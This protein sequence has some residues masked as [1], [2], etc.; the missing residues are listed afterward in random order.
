MGIECRGESRRPDDV[1]TDRKGA[2]Y[3]Q[4]SQS[5][6]PQIGPPAR[7]V[8]GKGSR[9]RRQTPETGLAPH[10]ADNRPRNGRDRYSHGGQVLDWAA[11]VAVTTSTIAQM[12]RPGRGHWLRVP[13]IGNGAPSRLSKRLE[14]PDE[15]RQTGPGGAEPTSK[16]TSLVKSACNRRHCLV[17]TWRQ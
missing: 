11:V 4:S 12:P 9:R 1:K 7:V 13:V 15:S 14:M 5:G 8:Q 2:P 17:S 10:S 16:T 3:F 6:A